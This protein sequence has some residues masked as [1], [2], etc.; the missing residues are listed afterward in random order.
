MEIPSLKYR[1]R[2]R[3]AQ[4]IGGSQAHASP[5]ASASVIHLSSHNG[6]LASQPQGP[7]SM[8]PPQFS[9]TGPWGPPPASNG[10]GAGPFSA[11]QSSGFAAGVSVLPPRYGPML[12]TDHSSGPADPPWYRDHRRGYAGMDQPLARALGGSVSSAVQQP[13]APQ[14]LAQRRWSL[15]PPTSASLDGQ[16]ENETAENRFMAT[17]YGVVDSR[18]SF[19]AASLSPRT[20]GGLLSQPPV[21][22]FAPEPYYVGGSYGSAGGAEASPSSTTSLP[23][24][25][26]GHETVATG[27]VASPLTDDASYG[28]TEPAMGY[29]VPPYFARSYPPVMPHAP[30]FA[31]AA[32]PPGPG[33]GP[34]QLPPPHQSTHSH[35]QPGLSAGRGAYDLASSYTRPG[36]GSAPGIGPAIGPNTPYHPDP[37]VSLEPTMSRLPAPQGHVAVG[38][39]PETGPGGPGSGGGLVLGHLPSFP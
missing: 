19:S 22:R 4:N 12:H 37:Y 25:T 2:T 3:R 9:N 18:S 16:V 1:H 5:H 23:P 29:S 32:P 14:D 7:T 21:A 34:E 24:P 17:S 13:P 20:R 26:V 33:S 27:M 39:G 31:S 28:Y 10:A 38:S 15:L 36:P 35:N 8:G 6:S 11:P 30:P